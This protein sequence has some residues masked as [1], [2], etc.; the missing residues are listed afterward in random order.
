MAVAIDTS[1]SIPLDDFNIFFTEIH[2]MWISGAEIEIIECDD[3]VQRVY[4]FNGNFPKFI[5]GRGGLF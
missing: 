5:S 1:A 2:S 4:D 3:T